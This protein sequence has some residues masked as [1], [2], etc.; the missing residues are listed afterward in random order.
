MKPNDRVTVYQFVPS[1]PYKAIYQRR[2]P[3]Q[4]IDWRNDP[5]QPPQHGW[6]RLK[7]WANAPI[8]V[9]RV[10]GDRVWV[11]SPDWPIELQEHGVQVYLHNCELQ[12]GNY[13]GGLSGAV[14][15]EAARASAIRLQNLESKG[16]GLPDKRGEK[17]SG[18]PAGEDDATPIAVQASFF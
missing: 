5:W 4:S 14:E 16:A 1:I 15:A 6:K 8:Y 9:L 11:F 10:E 12:D 7:C 17:G 2:A 3:Q 18:D 13:D